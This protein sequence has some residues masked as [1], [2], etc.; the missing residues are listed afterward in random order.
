[1]KISHRQESRFLISVSWLI[2]RWWFWARL[3]KRE[4][5]LEGRLIKWAR[6]AGLCYEV[7]NV[8][9]R[10]LSSWTGWNRL[11]T[12]SSLKE[13]E[14]FAI[15]SSFTKFCYTFLCFSTLFGFFPTTFLISYPI[16]L[17]PFRIDLMMFRGDP[18]T[19]C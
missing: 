2:A 12:F 5:I 6:F 9:R 10:L 14:I 7:L 17:M 1:M 4:L 13:S 3:M 18:F 15:L 19:C 8:F 11:G 16:T